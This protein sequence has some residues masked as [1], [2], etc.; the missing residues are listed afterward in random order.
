M[1]QTL[2]LGVIGGLTIG[3]LAVGIVLVYKANRFINLG[4]AQLG[5]LSAVL[6]AKWILDWGVSWWPAFPAAIALGVGTGLVVERWV[7]RPL[8]RT[9]RSTE[10]LML[11]TIGVAQLL[12]AL[13]FIPALRPNDNR[14]TEHGYPLPFHAHVSVGGVVLDAQYLLILA[15][16][17]LLVASLG[18]FLRYT[19]M[20]KMI[21]AAASNPEE[22]RL[23]G[24]SITRVSAVVWGIAGGLS[25]V[26]AVLLAPGQASFDAAQLGPELLLR[27]LGAAAVGGFTSVPAACVGG[28]GLGIIEQLA[29]YF[30]KDGSDALLVVFAAILVVF[31]VRARP[32][33]RAVSSETGET[34]DRPPLRVPAILRDHV[35]VRRQ[36][37]LL[38]VTAGAVAA[39]L[40]LLPFFHT[41]ASRFELSLVLIYAMVGV[42]LT[43]VVG[44]AG[45]ISLGHF[46]LVG[47]GAF[48]TARLSPHEWSLVA[49]VDLA[50]IAGAAALV[51]IGLPAL[52]LRGLTLAVTTLGLAVVAP[53]WLFRQPWFGSDTPF[54][55]VVQPIAVA[56]DLGTPIAQ[57]QIY[58]TALVVL[59]LVLLG[60]SALRRSVP[61]RLVLA[62]RD[63]EAATAAFGVTPAT[64]K[65]GVLAVS[66]FV[67]GAA[68][69]LWAEAWKNVSTGQFN[70]A[71]SLGILAVPVIGGLGSLAGAVA[72]AALLYF[73]TY[74]LAPLASHIFGDFG[75][76]IGFQ[77][78]VG[79][80]ALVAV[81]L[82]YPTGIAGA[83]QRVWERVLERLARRVESRP[84][85]P[86]EAPLV[87]EGVGLSFG[88]LRALDAVA[89]R[90]DER[91]IV[92]L[93]GANGA[94]KTTLLNAISGAL[95]PD[96]GSVRVF[97][98]EV[99]DLAP[100]YRAAFG[101]ARSF[102]SAR[103]FPGLTVLETMQVALSSANRVGVL[104]SIVGAPWAREAERR[105]TAEAWELLAL[106][107]L[108]PWAN[109]LTADLS[110][111]TRRICD[112]AAQMA[113]RPRL[114]VLDEPTAGVAQ[115]ETESFGPLLRRIRDELDCS[116]LIVEH[117]MPMLMGLCDRVYAMEAGR[118]IAEGTPTD[119]R[120]DPAVIGSYLGTD[121]VAINRSGRSGNGNSS[122]KGNGSRRRKVTAS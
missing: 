41:E 66:G 85:R 65:L 42:A 89:I 112:L 99:V 24:V 92:G 116:I 49:L 88:G 109:S 113:T 38:A 114:L 31:V 78:A 17:P 87:V 119:V 45:Q 15:V 63:N 44:W 10:T 1:T 19:A 81:T 6:L 102:Q 121:A 120:N 59:A 75:K 79:G 22:A 90:V 55:V 46:A 106:F 4:H 13:V 36:R 74:F 47:V 101:L 93:I 70:P 122:P 35:L 48:I 18:A 16:V 32:L 11:V 26:T 56:A 67:A 62:V 73:P 50:G 8:R 76:H 118:V 7:I 39:V 95:R 98:H 3:L 82:A 53:V 72:A 86:A 94:G 77:L 33:D 23:C 83:A 110:T 91:E 54:G 69:V 107:N 21:R 103:L 104:S 12:L 97:G 28:L 34:T 60:A 43:I 71:L 30:T 9:S 61:G 58:Y 20:G 37:A 108:E 111:G 115:R 29:L 84:E 25:A 105:T 117:D 80:A 96:E 52:R 27:A 14:L 57:G 5:A 68:G 100:E 64:V 40:P 51:A 2:V